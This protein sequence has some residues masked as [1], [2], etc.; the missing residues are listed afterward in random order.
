MKILH[1]GDCNNSLTRIID[2][3]EN[4]KVSRLIIFSSESN[5][6]YD[7]I[8]D[9]CKNDI[10]F[11][12]NKYKLVRYQYNLPLFYTYLEKFFIITTKFGLINSLIRRVSY[13]IQPVFNLML[14]FIDFSDL[15]KVIK[16]ENPD[17]IWSGSNNFDLSNLLTWL[18]G[19]KTNIKIIRSYKETNGKKCLDEYMSILHSHHLVLPNNA[20]LQHFKKTYNKIN[21]SNKIISFADEDWRYSRLIESIKNHQ[22]YKLSIYDNNPHVVILSGKV[23]FGDYDNYTNGRY[24]YLNLIKSFINNGVHVHL[25]CLNIYNSEKNCIVSRTENPYSDLQNTSNYFHMEE[26]L[27]LESEILNYLILKKYDAG[28]LHNY[29]EGEEITIFSKF[30]IPNRLYEYQIADVMPIVIKGTLNE[31]EKII[32]D[33]EFGIIEDS[34]ESVCKALKIIVNDRIQIKPFKMNSYLNFSNVILKIN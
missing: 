22:S 24:N 5:N 14:K 13:W 15:D 7:R 4:K 3:L 2:L 27:N 12:T 23:T 25:H 31:V 32:K 9:S 16:S 6:L 33:T 1:I 29:I 19:L 20:T 30:N 10:F 34:Y 21:W 17:L 28:I 8:I 18:T 11:E 26:P